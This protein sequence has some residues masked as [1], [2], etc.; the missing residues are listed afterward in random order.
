MFFDVKNQQ[1]NEKT[2][3]YNKT[4]TIPPAN[5]LTK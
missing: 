2:Y 5:S 1:F 4:S 3:K